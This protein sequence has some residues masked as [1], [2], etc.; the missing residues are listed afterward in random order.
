[1]VKDYLFHYDLCHLH[2][3]PEDWYGD[4]PVS[5]SDAEYAELLDEHKKWY[6]TKEWYEINQ[7]DANDEYFI[8]RFCP[9]IHK[10]VRE[11]FE[12]FARN[13]WENEITLQLDSADLFLPDEIYEDTDPEFFNNA[14]NY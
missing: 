2:N 6:K 1:M 11:S 5:L 10:K 12:Q 8:H 13:H 7:P 9:Q 4:F 14:Q 3:E